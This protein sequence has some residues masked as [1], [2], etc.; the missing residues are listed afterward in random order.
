MTES[1]RWAASH[2]ASWGRSFALNARHT[3]E[4][5]AALRELCDVLDRIEDLERHYLRGFEAGFAGQPYREQTTAAGAG[6][7][8]RST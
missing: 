4:Q 2:L 7:A 8:G 3:A 6:G 5:R 1:Q